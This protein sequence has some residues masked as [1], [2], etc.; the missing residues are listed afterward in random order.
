M[1]VLVTLKVVQVTPTLVLI[2]N[3]AV[4]L[5]AV[6]IRKA[7]A[8]A[9]QLMM[10]AVPQILQIQSLND[11]SKVFKLLHYFYILCINI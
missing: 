3:Q 10:R 4:I 5:V 6:R 8:K 2:Q 9:V 7:A 11:H 1:V